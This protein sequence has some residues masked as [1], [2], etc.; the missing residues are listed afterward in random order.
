MYPIRFGF[1][2]KPTRSIA[3]Y[4]VNLGG[5]VVGDNIEIPAFGISSHD[6]RV[7]IPANRP[8]FSDV[9]AVGAE[10]VSGYCLWVIPLGP[11]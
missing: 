6:V 9:A 1:D 3:E 7:D 4:T 11:E 10:D 2:V 5:L 8:C